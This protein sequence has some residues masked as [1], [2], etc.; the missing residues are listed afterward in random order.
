MKEL[1]AKKESAHVREFCGRENGTRYAGTHLLV[2]IWQCRHLTD[3]N[4][5]R[6]ILIKMV[7]ACGATMLNIDL[8]VFSPNGGISGVAVLKESH[9]N[10]HTWPEYNYAAVDIFVCGSINPRHVLPVLETE[11][12]AG[13]IEYQEIKR[14]ILP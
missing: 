7:E 11:F 8:H 2:E 1:M 12:Q 4:R 10:I 14:G 6:S 5:I 9:I 13:K 3:E